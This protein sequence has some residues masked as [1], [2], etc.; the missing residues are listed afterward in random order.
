VIKN[1]REA[2]WWIS[3]AAEKGYAKAKSFMEAKG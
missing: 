1:K 3:S 2:I